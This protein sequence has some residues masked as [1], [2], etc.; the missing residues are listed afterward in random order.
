ML[1]TTRDPDASDSA[2]AHGQ[3]VRTVDEYEAAAKNLKPGDQIIL[4]NGVWQNFDLVLEA[5]GTKQAPIRLTAETPGQVILS[6]QSSLR[7]AGEYLDVSGLVFRDG[8]TP[9]GEV[10]SFRRDSDH[11][12]HNSRVS[13]T[14]IEDYSNPDRRQVDLWVALYGKNNVFEHNHL[15]GKRNAGP[16]LAVRLDSEASHNNGHLIRYNYFGPRPVFGSNGGETLRIGTSPY[17]L[18]RSGTLVEHNYFDRCSGEVEIISNKSG[19]NIFRNNTFFESQGTLTLRHGSDALVENNL[20]DG[21]GAPFTGGVRIINPRQ[22]IRNNYFRQLTGTRFSAALVVMNGIYD[23]PINRYHQVDGAVIED[24]IF[25]NVT[26]IELGEGADAERTAPPI[27]SVFRNN[28]VT[29]KV[30]EPILR[31]QSAMDG[32]EFTNNTSTAPVPAEI[33]HGFSIAVDGSVE[34]DAKRMDPKAYGVSREITGV[35][36]YPKADVELPF[37]GGRDIAVAP[38]TGTLAVAIATA[39]PGDTLV[40]APGNYTEPTLIEITTP[41]TIRAADRTQPPA[42]TFERANL[43][44][45]SGNGALR[46]EGLSVSG[47]KAPDST[48]NSFI[49]T[50]AR[51]SSRNHIVEMLDMRFEDFAVNRSFSVLKADKGTFFDRISIA[52]SHFRNVSGTILKLD[53]ETDNFGIYSADVVDISD[54]VFDQVTEPVVSIY[55]GGTD[56]STFGPTVRVHSSSFKAVGAGKAPILRLHGVQNLELSANSTDSVLGA[57]LV[58]TTGTPVVTVNDNVNIGVPKGAFLKTIDLRKGQ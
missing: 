50:S 30:S 39:A 18:S 31:V 19:G 43:F 4:A 17:S 24:N 25:E 56:E 26:R 52:S 7:L 46:L 21:N 11:L 12:A 51:V 33:A 5:V 49:T 44:A 29:G 40:L 55:R 54:S 37:T 1:A 8:Y 28:T 45:L 13:Q 57:E 14:V 15:S 10:V 42:L 35:S 53:A 2:N 16:T 34:V 9:R 48:G 41:L 36:W 3:I 23:S 27:N 6:G 32:V 22:T 58:I 38:G 47:L 20:F